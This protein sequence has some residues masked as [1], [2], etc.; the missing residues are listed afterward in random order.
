MLSPFD[1]ILHSLVVF[2]V[3][4]AA[5]YSLG[6]GS[7]VL[8]GPGAKLFKAE[9]YLRLCG[10]LFILVIC[11]TSVIKL[12]LH[13][14]FVGPRLGDEALFYLGFPFTALL[15]LY[16]VLMTKAVIKL[17]RSAKKQTKL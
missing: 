10:D 3:F 13:F 15:I 2:Y 16:L 7:P 12:A 14:N 8:N 9:K 11:V 4:P 6:T 5:L 1:L 17:R